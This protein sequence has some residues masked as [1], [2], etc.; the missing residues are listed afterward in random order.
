MR[1]RQKTESPWTPFP[2]ELIDHICEVFTERFSD[3]YDL[4]GLHFLAEG[5]IYREE[6]LL[7]VGLNNPNQ[8]K[9]YNFELSVLY[10]RDEQKALD[11][12]QESVNV[13][14]PSFVDLLEEDFED[15]DFPI[16]W[17]AIQGAKYMAHQQYSTV[18]TL[19]ESEADKLLDE[20]EKKLLH[21]AEGSEESADPLD[22]ILH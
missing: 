15:A 2:Q 4:E 19:L 11:V 21:E 12:I 20:F 3:E 14:E 17:M 9:Q 1:P 6:I 8:L 10:N 16:E 18:N 22:D 7:R 5:R 13:L